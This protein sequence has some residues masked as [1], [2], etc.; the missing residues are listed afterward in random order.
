MWFFCRGRGKGD[1]GGQ[2]GDRRIGE[3]KGQMGRQESGGEGKEW[4]EEKGERNGKKK[5]SLGETSRVVAVTLASQEP[6]CY[7]AE[8]HVLHYED[9][10]Q[11]DCTMQSNWSSRTFGW[12]LEEKQNRE[13]YFLLNWQKTELPNAGELQENN[14]ENPPRALT[15]ASLEG[16]NHHIT[17]HIC[18]L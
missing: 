7:R 1:M 2:W 13:K 6:L 4:K 17:E 15:M 14:H 16:T 12:G 8:L 11:W 9:T 3:E 10:S 5:K 18:L